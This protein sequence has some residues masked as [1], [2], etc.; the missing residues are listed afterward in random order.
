VPPPGAR[1]P[2]YIAPSSERGPS[3]QTD[4]NRTVFL[5]PLG[6]WSI[7]RE[8]EPDWLSG[9][10]GRP[11]GQGGRPASGP[12]R[13]PVRSR[14]FW[15][16]LDDRKSVNTLLSLCKPDVWAFPPYFLITPCRNRQTP[17]LV[18]FCQ[19]KP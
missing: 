15:S 18:E 9:Q 1:G 16:L 12:V 17:K 2:A 10:G 13:P 6:R 8:T 14:G 4:I 19:I 3:D 5:D 11:R 7:I